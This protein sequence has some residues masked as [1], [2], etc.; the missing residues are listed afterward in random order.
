M[1]LNALLSTLASASVL[2][3]VGAALSF[4]VG[5]IFME[6]SNGLSRPFASLM[7]YVMFAAGASL[8]TLATQN[9]GMG[10]TYILV[11]GLEAVLA[12]VF[13]ALLFREDY[14]FLKLAGIFLV[15]MGI[16]FLRS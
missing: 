10:L 3:P 13:S 12:V 5:G 8:Q 2:M 15:T 16:T 14:T 4:T 6:L 9:S 11:L 1:P 7:V